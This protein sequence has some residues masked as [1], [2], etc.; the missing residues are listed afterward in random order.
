MTNIPDN[1]D[2][3]M[4]QLLEHVSLVEDL[5]EEGYTSELIEEVLEDLNNEFTPAYICKTPEELTAAI[6]DMSSED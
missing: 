6:N 2:K 1:M 5:V 3:T 4:S